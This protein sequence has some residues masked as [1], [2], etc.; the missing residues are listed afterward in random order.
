MD[1]EVESGEKCMGR[2]SGT[3]GPSAEQLCNAQN[4]NHPHDAAPGAMLNIL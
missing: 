1:I 3:H 2:V 4:V